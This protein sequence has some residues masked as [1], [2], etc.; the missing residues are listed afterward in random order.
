MSVAAVHEKYEMERK[1]I[2]A[3]MEGLAARAEFLKRVIAELRS[4]KGME[5]PK[6][7][8]GCRRF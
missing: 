5:A 6:P 4:A 2:Q 7:K 8:R 3:R 1:D